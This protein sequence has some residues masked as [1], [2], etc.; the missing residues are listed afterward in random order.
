M[1]LHRYRNELMVLLS[2]LLLA[3]ALLYKHAQVSAAIENRNDT[4]YAVREF[5][6]L[7][8]LKKRWGDKQLSKRVEKLKTVV[9]PDKIKWQK[10]SK[11]L[12][13]SYTGLTPK[14]LNRVMTSI[15]NLAIQIEHLE[16][17]NRQNNYDLELACKW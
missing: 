4:K 14:E 12:K 6:E 10:K 13:V 9:S 15:L 3:G 8:A 1:I 2:L 16:I 17:R 11:K 5:K 7:I